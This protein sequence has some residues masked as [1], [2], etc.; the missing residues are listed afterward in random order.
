MI[1][2]AGAQRAQAQAGVTRRTF[3]KVT[4]L[5]GA[6]FVIGFAPFKGALH[7]APAGDA[8]QGFGPFIRIGTDNTVTVLCKHLDKGQGVTTGLPTIVAEELDAAWSQMRAE[9]APANAKLYQNLAF[10][11]QGTGGSTAIANSWMQ[12][13]TAGAA[14]RAMLCEAAAQRWNV[15]VDSVDVENGVVMHRASKRRATF[16]DLAA[17][18]ADIEPPEKPRLKDP[19]EFKLIGTR[20]P[21]LDSPAKTSGTAQFT[22]D[23]VRPGMLMAVVAHPPRF[24]SR[25][26]SFD[27]AETRKLAGVREVV[28]IPRGVA[29]LADG[30]WSATRGRDALKVEWDHS[31]AETRGSDALMS[32]YKQLAQKPGAAI[33]RADGDVEAALPKAAKVLE[34][35]FEFPYLAHATMEPMN[36]V[37]ELRPDRCEIWT[38]S[39]LQTVDQM[40]A[41]E[42]TGLKPE[43]VIIH[44]HFAGGSFG[45]RAVPDSDYIAEAVMIAK[46]I[47]GR[48]PVK[49]Q[50][51]REDDMRGGRYRPLT[52]HRLRG[53]LDEAGNVVA[54]DQ[55]VVTQSIVTKTLFE[56]AMVKGGVDH[57]SVEGASNLPYA[58]ANLR[59]DLHTPEV[60]VPVLWWRSV[61][62]THTAFANEVFLDELAH[63]AKQDPVE[64]RRRLLKGHPRHLGV[65]NLAAEKAGW[66]GA[67]LDKGRG[68]GVAVHESFNSFVAEIADVAI[69]KKGKLRVERVVCAVDCGIAVNPDVI[70]AQMEGGIGYGLSAALREAV[71]LADGEVQTA[72]FDS[73]QP[74]RIHEMPEIE[75][76]IVPS[77]AAP[78]G[79]GE[80]GV[81]PIA[82]AVVNAIFAA[83]GKRIRSLPLAR[84]GF[85]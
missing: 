22:I 65:L 62:N 69:D 75:V 77:N 72:N 9:F 18:A 61:G 4:S 15:P 32:H 24:G 83:T 73:Y 21:R 29:V 70:R 5:A 2:A 1:E 71:R 56:S 11:V 64:L 30:Y 43:Q 19:K 35:E 28:E 3:L 45:R 26:A 51:S 66:K 46:A 10:G 79:V 60:G 59:V 14:A 52:F 17:Q 16:G 38:G 82:P 27:A 25:V 20:L 78:T 40:V 50:W 58:I 41:A 47:D 81:P 55:R 8:R 57:T 42:I 48:A 63:A 68:R 12:L 54:W 34:A 13:R 36:C 44:T 33:A 31:Q 85:V 67:K 23:V 6:G 7:A 80:P 53:A 74:L 37:V 49:L 84:H 76:H 39:Q